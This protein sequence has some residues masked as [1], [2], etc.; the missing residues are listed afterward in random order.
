M[1]NSG[2]TAAH[3]IALNVLTR[4]DPAA[5]SLEHVA[6][7]SSQG[8]RAGFA[9]FPLPFARVRYCFL[10][11]GAT[12]R[13]LPEPASRSYVAE[14]P[15][16][17]GQEARITR[18]SKPQRMET[19]GLGTHVIEIQLTAWDEL[20]RVATGAEWRTDP[21][22]ATVLLV[23]CGNA[24]RE[25]LSEEFLASGFVV[26]SAG[27]TREAVRAA[28]ALYPELVVI[29]LDQ[30]PAQE[31]D[32]LLSCLCRWIP[33]SKLVALTGSGSIAS[34]GRIIQRGATSYLAKPTTVDL[35]LRSVRDPRGAENGSPRHFTLQR[36]AWEYIQQVLHTAGSRAEAAR[37]LGIQPRSLRR[38]LEKNP[39]RE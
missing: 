26:H 37:R 24:S 9:E 25:K 8:A 30:I 4:I 28:A 13:L 23:D 38:M 5:P 21:L 36:A 2:P 33:L 14:V 12:L 7:E 15:M 19:T 31:A 34:A 29:D 17:L 1:F 10:E 39:P 35:I 18:L 20:D 22:A 3:A 32:D 11:P 6:A 16:A 27:T